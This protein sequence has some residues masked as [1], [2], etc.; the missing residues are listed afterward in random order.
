M[1][2]IDDA[3]LSGGLYAAIGQVV[4]PLSYCDPE[5]YPQM[6]TK[7]EQLSARVVFTSH[8]PSAGRGHRKAVCGKPI[9]RQPAG[10]GFSF[11]RERKGEHM[12]SPRDHPRDAPDGGALSAGVPTWPGG[13]VLGHLKELENQDDITLVNE[14]EEV[15]RWQRRQTG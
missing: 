8:L 10:G 14:F 3:A 7:I 13:S 4:I 15:T 5:P 9:V 6:L 2:L 1:A 12:D 11:S